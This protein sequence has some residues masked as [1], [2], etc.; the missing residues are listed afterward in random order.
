MNN[1]KSCIFYAEMSAVPQAFNAW[2]CY[3]MKDE[4]GFM[5][6]NIHFFCE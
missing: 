3:L 2:K 5:K 6:F 4:R 1:E